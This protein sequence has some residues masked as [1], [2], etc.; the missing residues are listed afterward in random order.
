[1]PPSTRGTPPRLCG[2]GGCGQ[3]GPACYMGGEEDAFA[4]F[5][6]SRLG[7]A[8]LLGGG[9][10]DDPV[11]GGDGSVLD[12]GGAD[13]RVARS[14]RRLAPGV[15]ATVIDPAAPPTLCGDDGGEEED[16]GGVAVVRAKFGP[17][18]AHSQVGRERRCFFCVG[19]VPTRPAQR[20]L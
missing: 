12:I 7:L 18:P 13:G 6:L 5:V 4:R 8:R 14:L 15:R 9:G 20:S 17:D 11:S 1:V 19:S 3:A 16:D 2:A 10:G